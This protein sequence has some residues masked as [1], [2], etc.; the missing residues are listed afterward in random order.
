[1]KEKRA[2]ATTGDAER[3]LQWDDLMFVH[4]QQTNK[5]QVSHWLCVSR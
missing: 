5:L 4:H 3:A 1:M 2:A